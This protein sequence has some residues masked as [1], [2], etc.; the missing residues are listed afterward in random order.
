MGLDQ[1]ELGRRLGVGKSAVN[2]WKSGKALPQKKQW[3]EIEKLLGVS[4]DY[5]LTGKPDALMT[6]D[7]PN[8]LTLE[9][10]MQ[11]AILAEERLALVMEQLEDLQVRLNFK[12]ATAA[13][14][15]PVSSRMSPAESGIL[16]KVVETAPEKPKV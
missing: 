1:A 15:K 7:A 14:K 4:M 5:L 12:P 11:R 2:H 10:W 3:P 16:G 13:A 6:R 9:Q 8:H